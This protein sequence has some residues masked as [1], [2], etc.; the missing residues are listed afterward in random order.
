MNYDQ[1]A[2]RET[3]EKIILALKDRGVIAKLVNTRSD[4]LAKL[5]EMIP[6]NADV[7]TGSST[8]LDEIGFVDLLKSGNHPW[9]NLKDQIVAEKDPDK[10]TKLRQK[11]ITADYFLGSIH[12]ITETGQILVASATGSQLPSYAFSSDHV[13]WVVGVQK[14]VP[15]LDDAFKRLK[16][17][18]FPLEDQR[19][20]NAGYLG[21]TIGKLLIF[22][23]ETMPNRKLNLIF[24]LEKLGF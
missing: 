6:A 2:S 8:T 17:Y 10:Q 19:M 18:V 20:K 9:H 22:E 4:A 5:R 3:I 13:I 7:V 23:K 24:V 12:A 14:I 1:L 15:T 16:E 21:S 11:S